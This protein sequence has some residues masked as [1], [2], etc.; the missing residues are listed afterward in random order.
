MLHG[1]APSPGTMPRGPASY[2]P[3][4]LLA[5]L[6]ACSGNATAAAAAFFSPLAPAPLADS[7]Q[8]PAL[9]VVQIDCDPVQGPGP[10]LLAAGLRLPGDCTG[11][12]AVPAGCCARLGPHASAFDPGGAGASGTGAW[13]AA[14]A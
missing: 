6:G 9:R 1:M 3:P 10:H 12:S 8:W 7:H 14:T 2:H 5:L 11:Q 13:T 4:D